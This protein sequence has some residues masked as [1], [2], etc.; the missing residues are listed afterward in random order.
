[1]I[2][3]WS[4]STFSY[5]TNISGRINIIF[6][7]KQSEKEAFFQLVL[8]FAEELL[9]L[10]LHSILNKRIIVYKKKVSIVER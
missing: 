10:Y 5:Y 6:F 8:V 9:I 1:M 3:I 2:V 4:I 7:V